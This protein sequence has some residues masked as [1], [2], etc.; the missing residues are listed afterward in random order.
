MIGHCEGLENPN[1]DIRTY[2]FRELPIIY[3]VRYMRL[4]THTPRATASPKCKC[5][6][7]STMDH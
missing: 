5:C 2:K 4:F 7:E 1:E 3:C 6:V